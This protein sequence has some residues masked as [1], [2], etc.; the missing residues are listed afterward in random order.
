MKYTLS[1]KCAPNMTSWILIKPIT[2]TI[3][4]KRVLTG[5]DLTCKITLLDFFKLK[6]LESLIIKRSFAI[7]NKQHRIQKKKKITWNL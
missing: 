5:Q 2:R 1:F 4:S 7:K 6:V 3:K